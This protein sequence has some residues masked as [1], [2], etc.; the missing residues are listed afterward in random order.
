MGFGVWASRIVVITARRRRE[1]RDLDLGRCVTYPQGCLTRS[2]DSISQIDG[3]TWWAPLLCINLQCQGR[4]TF[5]FELGQRQEGAGRREQAG[6]SRQEGEGM[7]EGSDVSVS[8]NCH[9]WL[10]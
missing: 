1:A 9:R 3:H 5:D 10:E 6:G 7:R 8:A 2:A 4:P